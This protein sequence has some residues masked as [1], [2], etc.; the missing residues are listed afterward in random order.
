[1]ECKIQNCSCKSE[2][3]DKL[4]GKSKRVWNPLQT[5]GKFTGYKCTVCG[6]KIKV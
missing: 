1:M 5:K 2:Q 3:Q 4:H 6:E